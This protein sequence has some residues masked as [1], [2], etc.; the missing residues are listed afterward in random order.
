[1]SAL[2]GK[3]DYRMCKLSDLTPEEIAIVEEAT[4]GK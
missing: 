3:I 1:M 4:R 2:E